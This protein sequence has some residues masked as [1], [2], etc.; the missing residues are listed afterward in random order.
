[1]TARGRRLAMTFFRET[2]TQALETCA[3]R[4]WLPSAQASHADS[5]RSRVIENVLV[6]RNG[7]KARTMAA[8]AG[9]G[10]IALDG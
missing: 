6:T 1:M 10:T 9:C 7:I 2:L 8:T 4:P 3:I 5:V